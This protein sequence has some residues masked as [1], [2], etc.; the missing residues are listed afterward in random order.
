MNGQLFRRTIKR[1]RAVVP[2]S[3]RTSV[4]KMFHGDIGHL[5]QCNTMGYVTDRI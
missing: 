5:E 4:M 3:M 1:I 2:V